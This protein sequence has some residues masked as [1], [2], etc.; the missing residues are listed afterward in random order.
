[1]AVFFV[2]KRGKAIMKIS[3]VEL[4]EMASNIDELADE[5]FLQLFVELA[6]IH[7]MD[8]SEE[9][10]DSITGFTKW[11]EDVLSEIMY[12]EC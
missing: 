6:E 12:K 8:I 3:T 2:E 9:D 5:D 11:L 1:M 7:D 4:K 10:S